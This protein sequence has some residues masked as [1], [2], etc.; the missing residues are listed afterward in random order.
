[1]ITRIDHDDLF[2]AGSFVRASATERFS[3]VNPAT[4]EIAGTVPVANAAD[5]DRAVSAA[6]TAF[7][8]WSRTSPAE[9][10]E[11]LGR[12]ADEFGKR[13]PEITNLVARQNGAPRWW[14]EQEIRIAEAVYRNAAKKAAQVVEE[15]FLP[16]GE[17]GTIVRREPLGVVAAIA[18][19]NG[20]EALLGMKLAA[21]IAAGCTV[22]AKPAPETSLDAFL[23]AEAFQAAGLP[24][25]VFN[26][27][28][29]AV[30]T[31]QALIAHPGID[32]VSFT[33]ST[34]AGRAIG[35]ACAGSFKEF[36]AELGG[37]SGA[38][39][40]GDADLDTFADSIPWRCIPFSGQVCH[41]ITR[42]IAPRARHTEVLERMTEKINSLPYGDP[43]DPR[44]ILGPVATAG[45]RD[46][47]ENYMRIGRDEGARLVLG[48]GRK[49]GFGAG[50]YLEPTIFTD[51][52]PSMRIFQEEI[53]G[54]VIS[55]ALYDTED[56]A[57]A[58]HDA[59]DFGLSGSVF[60]TDIEHA[61]AFARR[62]RT[63]EVLING[64]HGAPNVDLVRS[65]YKYSSLGGGMDLVPGYQ[66]IKSI[67]RG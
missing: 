66:L 54:P 53:F 5:V 3:A 51:T 56:E 35:A 58:L 10:S 15:E 61:T 33:G 13:A 7:G 47:V 43:A 26:L 6:R 12:V 63:G 42:V 28:T 34:E 60:S 27:V 11:V 22:V 48:G 32:K 30:D 21:V 37:K 64:K 59:T 41:A 14:V 38:V 31:G 19:W 39:L 23:L 57:A 25:G 45:Q 36:V 62:I 4:E 44:T 16:G 17:H 67:P 52:N 49:R 40:L 29:G 2:I 24:D 1:M 50:Y 8:S 20:P 46:R 18:P 9:R 55:V 65:F